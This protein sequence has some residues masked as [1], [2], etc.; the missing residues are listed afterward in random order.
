MDIRRVVNAEKMALSVWAPLLDG[1]MLP[2]MCLTSGTFRE[3]PRRNY[4]WN[5]LRLGRGRFRKFF[6]REND[7][8]KL[9]RVDGIRGAKK[10]WWG[11][12]PVF[13]IPILGGWR[14][15]AVLRPVD[16]R[17]GE[18]WYL[19]RFTP[20]GCLCI[21]KIPLNPHEPVRVLQGD[22]SAHFFALDSE[23]EIITVAIAGY[24]RIGDGNKEYCR[25]PLL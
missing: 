6:Y 13:L 20:E 1:V 11:I 18:C 24:G 19:G 15:Y 4:S 12:V 7:V 22:G 3:S 25:L 8:Q 9:V 23:F 17:V 10:R 2:L 14:D 16:L 5:N 21:S